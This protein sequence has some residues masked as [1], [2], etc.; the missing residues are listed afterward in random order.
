M[1]S[2]PQYPTS[3]IWMESYIC[4]KCYK[5]CT[6]LMIVVEGLLKIIY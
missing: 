3:S 2:G 5:P 4:T 6:D 1:M